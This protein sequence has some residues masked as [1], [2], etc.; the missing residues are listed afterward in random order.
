M[1][2]EIAPVDGLSDLEQAPSGMVHK[3]VTGLRGSYGGM[4]MFGMM[5]T[6][7]GMTMINPFSVAAGVMLGRKSYKEDA[8]ARL[9]RRRAEAK[10]AVRRFVDDVLFEVGRESRYRL[11]TIQRLLRDHFREIAEQTTR[12]LTE[13]IKAIE[14]SAR[15]QVADRETRAKAIEADLAFLGQISTWAGGGDRE[16]V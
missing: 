15:T 16:H 5:S 8:E 13:S 4:M 14:E 11:R 1:G 3:L 9:T 10:A 12:S 2:H 6:L 7:V